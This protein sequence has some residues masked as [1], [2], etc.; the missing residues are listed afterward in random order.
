MLPD[1]GFPTRREIRLNGSVRID[2]NWLIFG[3]IRYDLAP[4]TR[5]I[6]TFS[7]GARYQNECC[8]AQLSFARIFY[9]SAELKPTTRVY[10]QINLKYLGGFQG[11]Q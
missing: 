2:K 4:E 6:R 10:V 5:G 7:F 3:G 9:N 8:T 11:N 1:D